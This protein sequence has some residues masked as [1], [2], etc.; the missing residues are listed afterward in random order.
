MSD[1]TISFGAA[2]EGVAKAA[3]RMAGE[4]A[5]VDR[6]SAR[7]TNTAKLTQKAFDK[8]A[9]GAA[10]PIG[11]FAKYGAAGVAIAGVAAAWRAAANASEA[12][13]KVDRQTQLAL[14]VTKL[15]AEQLW[16][17]LGR[18]LGTPVSGAWETIKAR[19]SDSLGTDPELQAKNAAMLEKEARLRQ[20]LAFAR[21]ADESA[22]IQQL[23]DEAEAY[24]KIRDNLE[25]M[26]RSQAISLPQFQAQSKIEQES[27]AEREKKLME[28]YNRR[29]LE[30]IRQ[31]DAMDRAAKDAGDDQ[32]F[33]A[34]E[35]EKLDREALQNSIAENHIQQ[36]R[37]QGMDRQAQQEQIA[38]E[39][40]RERLAISQRIGATDKERKRALEQV[41]ATE[42][43][44]LKALDKPEEKRGSS[45]TRSL[46]AGLYSAANVRGIQGAST[47]DSVPKKLD[48][49]KKILT[50]MSQYLKTI[51]QN[52]N[53]RSAIFT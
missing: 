27:H 16:Q 24:Q 25:A 26:R 5:V 49:Q 28:G 50:D 46:G 36:L 3:R 29:S 30:N 15:K 53:N 10:G 31:R 40:A 6:A 38:L 41:N 51:A 8:L 44:M 18:Q 11:K 33:Q 52:T 9:E 45:G 42:A 2:D 34:Y 12:Y 21:D 23:H 13:A 20:D 48:D 19:V 22:F 47:V 37:A 4:L 14:D 35:K 17:K 7:L 32:M 1:V 43:A 39:A